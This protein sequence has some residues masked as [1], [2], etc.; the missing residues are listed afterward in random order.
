V[1]QAFEE[2]LRVVRRPGHIIIGLPN[3]AS[4]WT[5]IEDR[6]RGRSR[7]AF[8]VDRGRGVWPWWRRNAALAYRKR[9]SRKA[10]FLYRQPILGAAHGGDADAVYYAA[11]VDLLRFFAQRGAR[12]VTSG[13]RVRL[14]WLGSVLPVELQGSTVLAW[15][16]T[17]ATGRE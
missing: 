4:L 12:F 10:Q 1:A 9:F 13:A 17:E 11:P 3:H 5:P 8:G 6:L 2:L 15:R 14:G 7:L 16:V